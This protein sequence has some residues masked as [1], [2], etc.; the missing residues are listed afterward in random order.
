[1]HELCSITFI[2]CCEIYYRLEFCRLQIIVFPLDLTV[3]IRVQLGDQ[4]IN[5]RPKAISWM[6]VWFLQSDRNSMPI[7][8]SVNM[9][10]WNVMP[11]CKH[12]S[13][14]QWKTEISLPQ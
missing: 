8:A 11:S 2:D 4:T 6:L 12:L 1:M 13:K 9:A 5:N 14:V 10:D 7:W 3:K